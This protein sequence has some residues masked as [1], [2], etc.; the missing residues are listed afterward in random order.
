MCFCVHYWWG[1][2]ER[3]KMFPKD[4]GFL[5]HLPGKGQSNTNLFHLLLSR[6]IFSS[7]LFKVLQY[8][9]STDQPVASP[10]WSFTK[11]HLNIHINAKSTLRHCYTA[12]DSFNVLKT[13]FLLFEVTLSTW[14]NWVWAYSSQKH[15]RVWPHWH[16]QQP[17]SFVNF[18]VE[19]INAATRPVLQ[20]EH[21]GLS[22]LLFM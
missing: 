14:L 17:K 10:A 2:R 16:D 1:K 20:Q 19:L 15:V 11:G 13:E 7:P 3:R 12:G 8:S 9:T 22:R 5:C 6:Y 18:R 4:C 21:F